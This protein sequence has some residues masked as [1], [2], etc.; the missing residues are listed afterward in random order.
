MI[1]LAFILLWGTPTSSNLLMTKGDEAFLRI[2]YPAA[3]ELYEAA[4]VDTPEDPDILWRMARVY[5]CTGEVATGEKRQRCFQKA[6]TYAR[7]CIVVDSL[8]PEGHVWLA[9]ALGYRALD[10]GISD[11]LAYSK[12]MLDEV[13][14]TLALNP[15]DDAAYSIKGSFYR[16]LGNAGWLQRTVANLFFGEVPAGGF[17]EA[18]VALKRAIN[19]APDI[20]RHHYELGV[21]Y[22][23]WGRTDEARS[24]LTHAATLPVKVAIDRERLATIQI[25][26]SSLE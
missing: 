21:L 15:N 18:E 11:Q 1:L 22:L 14:R 4:L 3:I 10:A 7:K 12:E 24:V 25:L 9:G 8:K 19:L 13:G 2:N 6:E 26:L 5:V 16:A 20:M 17:E 23:D